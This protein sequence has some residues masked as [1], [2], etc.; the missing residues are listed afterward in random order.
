MCL[1]QNY[2]F[3]YF[4]GELIVIEFRNSIENVLLN[5]SVDFNANVFR[6]NLETIEKNSA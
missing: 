1:S 2:F 6:N 3:A 5:K 4:I